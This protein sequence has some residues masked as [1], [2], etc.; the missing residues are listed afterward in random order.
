M[1][2]LLKNSTDSPLDWDQALQQMNGKESLVLDLLD[3]FLQSCDDYLAE[4]LRAFS[5]G[6]NAR[7]A[8]IAHAVKGTA[9]LLFA[10]PLA[11]AARSFEF[12]LNRNEPDEACAALEKMACE[13]ERLHAFR[14]ELRG[15]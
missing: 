4:M 6:D 11:E 2:N 8:D 5:V 3:G 13:V 9:G 7:A 12:H 15:S 1:P 14:N 10:G